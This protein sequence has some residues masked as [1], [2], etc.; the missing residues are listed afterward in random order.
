MSLDERFEGLAGRQ[1]SHLPALLLLSASL[2]RTHIDYDAEAALLSIQDNRLD[3]D[4]A[5]GWPSILSRW[6][7]ERVEADSEWTAFMD[8]VKAQ[9]DAE[10]AST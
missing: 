9:L 1:P 6:Y 3:G 7:T 8:L 4:E 10:Q 5:C 2:D